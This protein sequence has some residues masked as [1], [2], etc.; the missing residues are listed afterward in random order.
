MKLIPSAVA[1]FR[2]LAFVLAFGLVLAACSAQ[3][4]PAPAGGA[5]QSGVGN[6]PAAGATAVPAGTI[7]PGAQA[8]V[9]RPTPTPNRPA[10]TVNVK[11]VEP[12]FKPQTEYKYDPSKVSVKVGTTIMWTNTGAVLHTVT[13]DDSQTFDSGNLD[14]KATFTF[15]AE[16]AGTFAYHCVQHPW[17]KGTVTVTQ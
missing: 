9:V 15:V 17:M 5:P 8:T 12:P 13:A 11:I 10:V 14:P 16:T 3:P 7:A 6:T 1:W 4:T 2:F